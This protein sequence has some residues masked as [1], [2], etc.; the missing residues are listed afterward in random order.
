MWSTVAQE[1]RTQRLAEHEAQASIWNGY[2][3][4]VEG[5]RL[6]VVIDGRINEILYPGAVTPY[7]GQDWRVTGDRLAYQGMGFRLP[8]LGFGEAVVDNSAWESPGWWGWQ[9]FDL[10]TLLAKGLPRAYYDVLV[11]I[12]RVFSKA[13][14]SLPFVPASTWDRWYA[15]VRAGG[16]PIMYPADQLRGAGK[17]PTWMASDLY[18]QKAWDMVRQEVLAL[19]QQVTAA[20]LGRI[21]NQLREIE[22][23]LQFWDT[24]AKWSGAQFILD[25]WT[26]FKEAV[27]RF[28]SEKGRTNAA[29]AEIDKLV[30]TA[31]N[32][33]TPTQ[34]ASL[35]QLKSQNEQNSEAARQSIQGPVMS[36]LVDEGTTVAG[37]GGL[38]VAAIIALGTVAIAAATTAFISYIS[39]QAA[40]TRDANAK[41]HEF[42][43]ARE[44]YDNEAF[45]RKQEELAKRREDLDALLTENKISEA[46][47]NQQ[48]STLEKE[49]Q[50]AGVELLQRREQ[51]KDAVAT[52][53]QNVKE[54]AEGTAEGLF[55]NLSTIAIAGAVGAVAIFVVPRL[56]PKRKS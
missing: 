11:N 13:R 53:N 37:L 15:A 6:N 42:T 10:N 28:N 1:F 30:I 56:L 4:S 38:P 50:A 19:N 52:Y 41:L 7:K 47:Y 51:T 22:Q 29:L 46:S 43:M 16:L 40:L 39:I 31:P 35:Q 27:A 44:A 5:L 36:L 49:A 17:L 24:V 20:D 9:N 21:N 25:K 3:S 55:S 23:N 34:L 33:F 12:L 8:T 18:K 45:R 26:Q 2:S 54:A 48:M 32:A 14:A